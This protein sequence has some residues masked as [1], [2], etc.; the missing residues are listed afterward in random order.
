MV[1]YRIGKS[2]S[3]MNL[4][5]LNNVNAGALSGLT[6]LDLSGMSGQFCGKLFADLGAEVLLIEPPGGSAVRRDGPFLDD[7]PHPETSLTFA[8]FNAGK[9]SVTID[10][11]TSE[12]QEVLRRLVANADL[13]IESERPGVMARRGLDFATLSKLN[14]RLVMTSITPFGQTGPYAQYESEDIVALALGGLLYLGGYP[15]HAPLAAYGQQAYLAAA[16]FAAVASM[17]S[18]YAAE[19]HGI[20]RHC[21]VSVQECVVL[22]LEN[23]VQ[24]FDLEGTVRKRY[25]GQ[26]RQAGMGVFD[27]ADGQVYFMAG[28]VASNKFWEA[29]VR[30]LLDEGVKD[31][32]CLLEPHWYDSAFLAT[33]GAKST[34][35]SIFGPF[36]RARTKAQ[37]YEQGQARRLPIC[38]INTPADL[39]DNRQL[40][41]R[42]HFTQIP[43]TW[44]GRKLVA[45]GA[46]YQFSAT[47]WRQPGPVP[48]LGEHTASVLESVG[49]NSAARAALTKA[50]VI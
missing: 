2:S 7:Q 26:Q 30:W 36:A 12:G 4:P 49:F 19:V 42:G 40:A 38:P 6:V 1:R 39:L 47:P 21:D 11:E 17:M 15:D 28:G 43:H 14:P 3:L 50:G 48:R 46:P 35:A 8:Y 37:L 32:A 16:Q 31:A 13:V 29:S 27:C 34:F 20:G 44:S 33:V 24:F 9:R 25:G 23:A 5:Q 18:I 10:L 41:Y 45:P 22:A